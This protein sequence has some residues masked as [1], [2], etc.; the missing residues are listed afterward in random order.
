MTYGNIFMNR[1]NESV[2]LMTVTELK[3]AIVGA[4]EGHRTGKGRA[5]SG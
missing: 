4:D 3:P 5:V 2:V 1:P